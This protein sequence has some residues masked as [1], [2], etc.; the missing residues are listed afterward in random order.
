MVAG[1]LQLLPSR[2]GYERN[3]FRRRG[4]RVSR[5]NIRIRCRFQ[6]RARRLAPA[7]ASRGA[8]HHGVGHHGG[9]HLPKHDDRR[10][11]GGHARV[12]HQRKLR[13]AAHNG[14]HFRIGP[15]QRHDG[16][17]DEPVRLQEAVLRVHGVVRHRVRCGHLRAELSL[18]AGGAPAAGR[19]RRHLPAAR[20]AGGAEHLPEK[21]VWPGHGHRG[22]D[23]RV[24]ARHRP[25]HQR[26]PHR[27]VG[28]ALHVLD[29]RRH[30]ARGDGSDGSPARRRGASPRSSGAFRLD[31]GASVFRRLR[32]GDDRCHHAG[33]GRVRGRGLHRPFVAGRGR[34]CRVRAPSAARSRTVPE[35]AM[36][37]RQDVRRLHAHR[38]LRAHDVHGAVDHGAAVRAGYPGAFRHGVG[39]D[40]SARRHHDGRDEPHHRALAGS[41]R[42]APAYCGGLRH[43]ACGHGG[44]CPYPRQRPRMGCHG[45][46]RRPRD[47]LS[48]AFRH[49]CSSL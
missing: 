32:A 4:E 14:I 3:L 28:L 39:P 44:V 43:G 10:A 26:L 49:R 30:H 45:A 48:E 31:I 13:P 27:R 18:P 36:L 38:H 23:H 40:A 42:P 35:A 24:R 21:P 33:I 41:S 37:P 5:E 7:A 19:R 11:A 8:G 25:D 17:S 12:R 6:T 1:A 15:D 20:A 2:Y 47:S 29:A 22:H 9:V 46:L 16:L 34:A